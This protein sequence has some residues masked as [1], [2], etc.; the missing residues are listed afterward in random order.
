MYEQ[1]WDEKVM[2]VLMPIFLIGIFTTIVIG[3]AVSISHYR[4]SSA[5]TSIEP[6][7]EY[8]FTTKQVDSHTILIVSNRYDDRSFEVVDLGKISNE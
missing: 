2:G 6:D 5:I 3:F 4:Y 8:L 7:K 1:T